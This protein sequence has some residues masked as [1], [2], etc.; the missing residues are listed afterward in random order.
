MICFFFVKPKTAYE[1][2]ISDWIS[3]VCS[4]DLPR[5]LNGGAH[6]VRCLL[7]VSVKLKFNDGGRCAQSDGGCHM[8]DAGNARQRIL[9]RTGDLVF[10]LGRGSAA[11][12]DGNGDYGKIYVGELFDRQLKIR[13]QPRQGQGK[14]QGYPSSKERRGGKEWFST[15]S[16]GWAPE[17]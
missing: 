1:M 11:L 6:V 13:D 3:D 15:G 10:N 12:G 16:S 7:H 2:R 9:D 5:A 17:Q 8:L 14:E 4:S